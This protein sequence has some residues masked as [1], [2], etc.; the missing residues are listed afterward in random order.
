MKI[1]PFTMISTIIIASNLYN[2]SWWYDSEVIL[3]F[4]II[5]ILGCL[6][7]MLGTGKKSSLALYLALFCYIIVAFA[8]YIEDLNN[9]LPVSLAI[10]TFIQ[11]TGYKNETTKPENV[12][13]QSQVED[14]NQSINTKTEFTTSNSG[15][16]QSEFYTTTNKNNDDYSSVFEV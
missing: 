13:V 8:F 15:D 6:L 11:A 3:V 9:F 12:N 4:I 1:S 16:T 10:I 14:V 5:A 2:E 7:R